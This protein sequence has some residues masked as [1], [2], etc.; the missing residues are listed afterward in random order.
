MRQFNLY[1]NNEIREIVTPFL[2][3]V[4]EYLKL[5]KLPHVKLVR[6]LES[7][8]GQPTFATFSPSKEY[9][10]VAYGNRHIAD[11][12]R[13]LAHELVHSRQNQAGE[14]HDQSGETGSDHEN[15]ANAEAGAILRLYSKKHPELLQ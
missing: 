13:S 11:I 5:E 6:S 15:E 14:L 8:S 3:F 10:E 9:I 12:L 1:S 2:K 4:H 7:T